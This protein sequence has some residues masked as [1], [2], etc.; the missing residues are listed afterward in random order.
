M[1]KKVFYV[2][3]FIMLLI[4]L[5]LASIAYLDTSLLRVSTAVFTTLASIG[6][7][8][9]TYTNVVNARKMLEESQ[10]SRLVKIMP[11]LRVEIEQKKMGY[12]PM[13]IIL[14]N[15]GNGPAIE[16]EFFF[17]PVKEGVQQTRKISCLGAGEKIDFDLGNIGEYEQWEKIDFR[18][19]YQDLYERSHQREGQVS[20]SE[21]RKRNLSLVR[22][23]DDIASY[24][25]KISQE[26]QKI[27]NCL[28]CGKL[29]KPE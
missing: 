18:I 28:D 15:V 29:S 25:E 8:C 27:A 26:L 7:T 24:L 1:D 9:L 10:Q 20:L 22:D 11:F 21:H 5:S 17:E 3:V 14:R 6:L 19:S 23:M 13:E 16:I 4:V 2:S 12:E